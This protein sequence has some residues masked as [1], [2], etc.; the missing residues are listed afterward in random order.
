MQKKKKTSIEGDVSSSSTEQKSVDAGERKAAQKKF[1][2]EILLL[3]KNDE[4]TLWAKLSGL[5]IDDTKVEQLC[6]ALRKNTNVISLDVSNNLLT[7][8]GVGKLCKALKDGAAPDLIELKLY[9]NPGL[10]SK[11]LEL[12]DLQ[13]VRRYVRIETTDP[14]SRKPLK[15]DIADDNDQEYKQNIPETYGTSRNSSTAQ[16]RNL[17]SQYFQMGENQDT[18]NYSS[19]PNQ[20]AKNQEYDSEAFEQNIEPEELSRFLWNEVRNLNSISE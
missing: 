4:D 9:K 2:D 17:V 16:D 13:A 19:S 10:D 15:V 12:E 11:S 1:K 14:D 6:S 8:I 3:S 7:D 5:Y 18:E 20:S